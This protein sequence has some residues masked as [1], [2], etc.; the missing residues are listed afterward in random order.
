MHELPVA[1][2]ILDIVI[3]NAGDAKS[4]QKIN[5]VMLDT[6]AEGAKLNF[7]TVKTKFLC[8]DCNSEYSPSTEGFEC[9]NCNSTNVK[10]VAGKEFQLSSIEVE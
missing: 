7:E 10:I 5:I 9:I 4:V 1:Q 3:Q 6:I 8:N 2:N